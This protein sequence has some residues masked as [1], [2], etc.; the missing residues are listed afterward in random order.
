[1]GGNFL[2]NVGPSDLGTILPEHAGRLREVGMW[3]KLNGE[4]IYGTRAGL[5]PPT[6]DMVSTTKGGAHYLHLLTYRSDCVRLAGIPDHL[7]NA[8]LLRN[9]TPIQADQEENK[10][11]FRIPGELRDPFDTVLYLD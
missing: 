7:R 2:L 8:K 4:S 10:V 3:L 11:T 9:G 5:I 1:M 6:N